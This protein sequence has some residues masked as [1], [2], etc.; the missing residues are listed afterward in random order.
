[1]TSYSA[2]N[3][4]GRCPRL[5]KYRYID[6]LEPKHKDENLFMGSVVHSLLEHF[7]LGDIE[8][9]YSQELGKVLHSTELFDD[10]KEEQHKILN[11]AYALVDQYRS[12]Y[13]DNWE[14]LHV[15]EEFH[16]EKF[17]G[18]ISEVTFTPDLVVREGSDVW[19]VDHKT[20]SNT[21]PDELEPGFADLQALL[22]YAGVK[23]HYPEV[24]GFIFNYLRKKIPST[25]RLTKTAPVRVANLDR[26]DTTYE[27]LRDF[28]QSEA[29]SL[30]NDEAHRQKLA[31]LKDRNRFF[32]R[33]TLRVDENSVENV[34]EDTAMTL[35]MIEVAESSGRFPRVIAAGYDGCQRCSFRSPCEAALLDWDEELIL[36]TYYKERETDEFQGTTD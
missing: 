16:L 17:S 4:Y 5:Y 6:N 1:M 29:P 21:R 22:Y 34:L 33:T 28:L 11:D 30:L 13:L 20:T 36:S 19:I 10:E 14:V 27:N 8:E 3:T 18:E 9:Y 12:T 26:L 25:P 31:E 24:R 23:Q 2:I 15:E 35:K 32:W 7:Y